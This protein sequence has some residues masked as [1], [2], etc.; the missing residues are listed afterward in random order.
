MNK[1]MNPVTLFLKEKEERISLLSKNS[2][3]KKL[4]LDFHNDVSKVNYSYNFSWMGRPIIAFPQDMIAMQELI[5]DIKPDLIIETG[6]AHGGSIVFYA[7]L[8]ELIGNDGLVLGIDIDIRK[9]NRSLIEMHP[10]M[11][12]IKL[13]EGSSLSDEVV[14][15]VETIAAKKQRIMV[16][17]DSNHTHEHVLKEL[18]LYA[19]LTSIESY[20]VVFDTVIED[21]PADWD[22]GTRPWGVGNNP[23]TAVNE[24]LKT[25]PEFK[26][27][28]NIDHKLLIS[29]APGGY[30]KRIR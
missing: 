3:L 19:P 25:H 9:H 8:L 18:E 12:R 6:I 28:K 1:E 15:E 27:D 11:K 13:I 16:C 21:M 30:L 14:K 17:L 2:D 29:V 7:S 24:Y 20:C 22:W 26:I 5:W 23:K 4:G 10:M